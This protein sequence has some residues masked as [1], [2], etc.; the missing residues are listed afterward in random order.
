MTGN[1]RGRT[2]VGGWLLVPLLSVMLPSGTTGNKTANELTAEGFTEQLQGSWD[3]RGVKVRARRLSA[4]NSLASIYHRCILCCDAAG[5]I[6]AL[7]SRLWSG[8]SVSGWDR[9]LPSTA[10]WEVAQ[11][12][13]KGWWCGEVAWDDAPQLYAPHTTCCTASIV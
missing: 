9:T 11:R 5:N 4:V 8:Q 3:Y 7:S 13:A 1:E 10:W 2:F 12:E 6:T